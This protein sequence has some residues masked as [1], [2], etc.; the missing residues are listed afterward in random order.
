[1]AE[2]D[3]RKLEASGR[4]LQLV[5]DAVRRAVAVEHAVTL[6]AVVLVQSGGVPKTS[7]GKPQRSACR[8]AFVPSCVRSCSG[9]C[10][11]TC[12][13]SRTSYQPRAPL[14]CPIHVFVGADDTEV[15]AAGLKG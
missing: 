6:H 11:P 15:R 12:A 14:A 10:A 1:M 7:S 8:E 9:S 5:A 13:R 4:A 3:E 2:L